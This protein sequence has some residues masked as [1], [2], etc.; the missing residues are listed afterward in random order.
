[1]QISIQSLGGE[2]V[3]EQLLMFIN[4][5]NTVLIYS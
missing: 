2:T 1:M 4:K 3:I 5:L